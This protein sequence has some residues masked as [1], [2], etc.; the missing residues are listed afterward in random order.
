MVPASAVSDVIVV[1]GGHN[2]LVCAAYLAEAGLSV[3]VLEGRDVI[4]GNTVT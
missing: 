1:G 4:G 2:A 3:T